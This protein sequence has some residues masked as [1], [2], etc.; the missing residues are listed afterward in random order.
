MV[1]P[2]NANL[3]WDKIQSILSSEICIIH[4]HDKI[5]GRVKIFLDSPKFLAIKSETFLEML[6]EKYEN[7]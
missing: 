4:G 3:K 6:C 7:Y 5:S 1:K 2:F